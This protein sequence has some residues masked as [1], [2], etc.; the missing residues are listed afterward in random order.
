[1]NNNNQWKTVGQS[2]KYKN[3]QRRLKK[4]DEVTKFNK[5]K[6]KILHNNDYQNISEQEDWRRKR[7][8]L[9]KKKEFENFKARKIT[10]EFAQAIQNER[11]K[12][13]L[14]RKDLAFKLMI[15][16]KDLSDYEN[17]L[18]C[19]SSHIVVK[20]RQLFDNLPKQ[21]YSN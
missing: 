13:K 12:K 6:T 1:M 20:F 17:G 2:K 14:S 16:E 7:I 5:T 21:Y 10:K 9:I 19:P 18:K 4:K 11:A 8:E 3:K 15:S